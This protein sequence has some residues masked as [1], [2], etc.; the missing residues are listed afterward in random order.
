[1][2]PEILHTKN[3]SVS[4]AYGVRWPLP[5]QYLE[6]VFSWVNCF[7]FIHTYPTPKTWNTSTLIYP[8]TQYFLITVRRHIQDQ[9]MNIP[10]VPV[11]P[12]CSISGTH[13][14]IS[15]SSVYLVQNLWSPESTR[16][17]IHQVMYFSITS[18]LAYQVPVS[19]HYLLHCSICVYLLQ[20][21]SAA[22]SS[23]RKGH[24]SIQQEFMKRWIQLTSLSLS[25]NGILRVPMARIIATSDCIVLL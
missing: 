24:L 15:G 9:E 16:Q 17:W 3:L 22:L 13:L 11:Y 5:F 20:K 8:R 4:C 7:K 23:A 14:I 1:M 19:Q 6:V 2:C 10:S 18:S 21:C 25:P 12:L